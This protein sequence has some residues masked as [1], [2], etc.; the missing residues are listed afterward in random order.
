MKRKSIDARGLSCPLPVI[1]AKKAASE[2]EGGGIVNIIVDNEIAVQNLRKFSVQKGFGV[3]DRYDEAEGYEVTITVP[4]SHSKEAGEMTVPD[5]PGFDTIK[6]G[7]V[8][9]LSSDKMGEGDEKLGAALM[10]GFVFALTKQD[11]L[12][13][14]I[15]CYNGGAHL[16]CDG[17]DTL[18][19]M[20]AMEAAGV[21]I[22]TCGTCLDFYGIKDRLAAGSVTNMYEITEI[23]ENAEHM[24]KP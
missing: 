1:N 12:P 7:L 23:M 13:E 5:E 18:E 16:T 17:S 22:L 14:T 11:R 19:D 3:S 24:V 4:G 6:K 20:K 21:N 10:N 15:I 2:M 8:V 9:V